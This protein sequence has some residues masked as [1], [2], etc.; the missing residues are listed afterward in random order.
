MAEQIADKGHGS[1]PFHYGS[2]PYQANDLMD[3]G[4][5]QPKTAV[6]SPLIQLRAYQIHDKKGGDALDN[7]LEAERILR[8]IDQD[9]LSFINEGNPNT[10]R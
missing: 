2:S 5:I 6:D 9:S 8:N 10:Q 3:S 7:W 1:A 4:D